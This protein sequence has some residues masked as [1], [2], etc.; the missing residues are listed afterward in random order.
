MNRQLPRWIERWL[1][2]KERHKRRTA[3]RELDK[4]VAT[5]PWADRREIARIYREARQRSTIMRRY[6]VDHIVPLKHP[7]VCGLHCEANLQIL[8]AQ[9]N[10]NKSNLWWPGMPYRQ[11]ELELECCKAFQHEWSF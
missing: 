11:D 4:L 2:S 8:E 5:P 3:R 1:H 7:L 10:A 6:E 9:E